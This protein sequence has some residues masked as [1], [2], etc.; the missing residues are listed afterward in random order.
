MGHAFLE[1]SPFNSFKGVKSGFAP[2][3]Q[4]WLLKKWIYIY[5]RYFIIE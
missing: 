1:A 4:K 2:L 5:K 3:F